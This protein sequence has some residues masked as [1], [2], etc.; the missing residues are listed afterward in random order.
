MQTVGTE[1]DQEEACEQTG[2]AR[3]QLDDDER[4]GV[5]IARIPCEN[6]LVLLLLEVPHR[7]EAAKKARDLEHDRA[8]GPLSKGLGQLVVAHRP[9][10]GTTVNG[11]SVIHVLA[12]P[13]HP[14]TDP[15]DDEKDQRRNRDHGEQLTV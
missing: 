4:R 8:D 2:D 13:G 15:N 6:D 7:G 1:V 3:Q 9:S 10:G 5:E 12:G 11:E 14:E